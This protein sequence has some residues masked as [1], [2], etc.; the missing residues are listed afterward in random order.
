VSQVDIRVL[1]NPYAGGGRGARFLDALRARVEATGAR[2]FVSCDA[3]DL[4]RL[5]RRAV[6]EGCDRVVAVGGDGTFHHVIRGLAGGACALGL[7][8]V[9]RGNDLAASLGVPT[10]TEAALDQALRGPSRPIDLGV[11]GGLAFG[12]YCGVGFD[13][14]VA[15]WVNRPGR[16]IKGPLAYV[17]GVLSTLTTFKA[18]TIRVEHDEGIFHEPAMFISL[19]NC[20]RFGGGMRIA[21]GARVD[22]GLLELVLVR[23][24][25]KPVLLSV[26]PKV[27]RGTHVSHPAIRILRTRR[28]RISLD[29]PMW[30]YADGEE[31]LR[32]GS[33][34]VEVEAR[35]GALQVVTGLPAS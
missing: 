31:L 25:S 28:A 18:P 9:G 12:V 20:P 2:T 21:P 10:E 6:E 14:E 5:A 1:V 33:A 7:V 26:F 24:V 4:T 8:P 29:R 3:A 15:R 34:P 13:S 22:D 30:L 17:L 27:Y 35:P 23:E 19:C 16:L 32:I 11:A